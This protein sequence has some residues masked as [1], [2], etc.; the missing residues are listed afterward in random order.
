MLLF[1]FEKR[2]KGFKDIIP[3]K[4]P[5]RFELGLED[6][7]SSV[8][9]ATLREQLKSSGI[10]S[11]ILKRGSGIKSLIKNKKGRGITSLIIK[12]GSG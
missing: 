8:I 9:T 11:L 1:F 6:S 4:L 3:D 5:P 10:T 12:R 7:K 2:R